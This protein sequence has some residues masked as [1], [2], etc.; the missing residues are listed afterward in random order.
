LVFR[1]KLPVHRTL[2][3]KRVDE[4]I[5]EGPYFGLRKAARRVDGVNA[6]NFVGQGRHGIDD[7]PSLQGF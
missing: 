7:Q 4:E 1:E 6:L 2:L 5:D 3:V